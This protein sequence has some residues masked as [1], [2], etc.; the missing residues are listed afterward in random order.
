MTGVEAGRAEVH[1]AAR[2]G[3]R[4]DCAGLVGAGAAERG[5]LAVADRAGELGL[6]TAYAPPAPQQRPSSSVSRRS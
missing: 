5:D 3:G 2:V 6:E 1:H 4:D